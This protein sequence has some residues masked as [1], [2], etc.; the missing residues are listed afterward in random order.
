MNEITIHIRQ[1]GAI[2]DSSITLSPV[3][4]FS[5]ESGLGKS[6]LAI[7]C[8]YFFDV[9]LDPNRLQAFFKEE[10]REYITPPSMFSKSDSGQIMAFPKSELEDWLSRDLVAYVRYILGYSGA[11]VDVTVTLPQL[12]N[13]TQMFSFGYK[14]DFSGL[15][16]KEELTY[17]L[18]I[19]DLS[20][21][22]AKEST[23]SALGEENPL[24][25][26][27]RHYLMLIIFSDFR[28]LADSV[29]LPPSRGA[30]FT[31]E[32]EAKTGLFDRFVRKINVLRR[33]PEFEQETDL[34]LKQLFEN[35]IR[36]RIVVKEDGYY[37]LGEDGVELPV[38]AVA[39][40]IR[41]I[42]PLSL[43]INRLEVKRTALLFEEP[44]AHLHPTLQRKMADLLMLLAER[45]MYMQITTHSDHLL[46]RIN[47]LMMLSELES[48]HKEDDYF[49]KFLKRN[50]LSR[51]PIKKE[52]FSRIASFY[53]RRREDGSSEIMK[54]N[55]TEG[56][57]LQSFKNAVKESLRVEDILQEELGCDE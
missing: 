10:K 49:V 1:L 9:L 20:Y 2:K 57:S 19:G 29:L 31:E 8:H 54:Q 46:R 23:F 30:Y 18:S 36:G 16:D 48:R 26:L 15:A 14:T 13:D 33:A 21:N 55:I 7:L 27:L 47:E 53:L 32:L 25:L 51:S 34:E 41:E 38:S 22:R 52:S 5:G 28:A 11:P 45:G 44:E 50:K 43:I 3:M 37:H 42:S 35:I 6:Y 56:I 4:F 12:E 39:S 40:S 17:T 24:A